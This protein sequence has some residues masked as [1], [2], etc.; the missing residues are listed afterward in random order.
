MNHPYLDPSFLVSWSRLT[1]EAIKPDITEAISR[2]KTNIQA[3]C[4]L[5]LD[6]LTYENTFGALEKASE[7]L[8]RGWG[9]IM[10]LDSVNDEPSQREAIGEMLPEVVA[11]S[12]SVSLN[13]M[14]WKVLKAAAAC[15]W[16]KDLSPVKQR[17]IQET[18][19]DFRES[20][21]D[22]PDEVKPEYA[23]IEAQLSLK[24]KKFAENVLDSTNA[25]ELVVTDEAE[26][27]GLPESAREAARLDA[28]ANGHG[29][30][31]KPEWRF[32]QKFTSLQPVLQFADSDDLRRKV[33]EGSCTIGRGGE[34]DNEALIA[35]I[36]DLR[37]RKARL[38]GFGTFVQRQNNEYAALGGVV[39]ELRA[40]VAL[41][42][43]LR[44]HH[45]A[46][47]L[48]HVRLCLPLLRGDQK[49]IVVVR[50]MHLFA[51]FFL[52]F[53]RARCAGL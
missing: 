41:A 18:L 22:L 1:P 39:N 46:Q 45:Q 38:L 7:D 17:F 44:N 8:N 6:S 4:D 2:A 37:D 27:S 36:L 9:R 53:G 48:A 52:F 42:H 11:F 3:I 26:L 35:E 34:Y 13:P 31:E 12:S 43:L 50:Q 40:P 23:E 51:H 29:T 19:A 14:L 15:D 20:G 16:V 28:L 25:W 10:H 49:K 5:P 33:W 30:E 32:T 24:T 47:L 21:A